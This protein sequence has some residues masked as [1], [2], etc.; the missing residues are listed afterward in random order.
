MKS[1]RGLAGFRVGSKTVKLMAACMLIG[2]IVS[3]QAPAIA[4]S[5][6]SSDTYAGDYEAGS[7]P[8][9]T[10]TALLHAGFGHSDAF[11]DTTGNALPNSHANIWEGFPRF[12]YFGELV[13]HP[14]VFDVEVPFATLTD[15]NVPGTNNLVNGGATDPIV[16]VTFFFVS[17]AQ[18]QR[19]LGLTNYLYIPLG[20]YNNQKA[21]NVGTANQFTDVPQIGYT[22][23]LGKFS[24]G[25]KGFFFDLVANAS[26][27]S[28]G[29]NPI[30]FINPTS[31]PVPGILSYDT[32]T[33]RPSYDVKAFL[34]YE[35]KPLEFLAL[36]IEKSWGGEQVAVNGRFAVT[37]LPL[38]IPQPPLALIKD[39]YLRGHLQFQVPL[40]QDFAVAADVFHDFDR[41]GGFRE[42]IG[43][44]IRLTKIFYPQ[45]ASKINS[46]Q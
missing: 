26:I 40:A 12:S 6:N 33:Q 46:H 28:N 13:G 44:E 11:V 15:V 27:H 1:L 20:A 24:P 16:D 9:G 18:T 32:L 5:D 19:W 7:L 14:L 41:V 45:P 43:A 34:R 37:G 35:F 21:V 22:E 38:V 39:D 4:G 23:G 31:A 25:L 42:D 36:G 10:F 30:N 17:D 2:S 29:R 8:T 3:W